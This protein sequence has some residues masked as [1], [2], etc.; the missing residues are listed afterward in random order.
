MRI[1][2]EEK[3]QEQGFSFDWTSEK[4][5]STMN[6]FLDHL[7]NIWESANHSFLQNSEGKE[8]YFRDVKNV[9]ISGIE[10]INPGDFMI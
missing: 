1:A 5:M 7:S 6:S 2:L 10:T 8:L 9:Q 4:A 3:S